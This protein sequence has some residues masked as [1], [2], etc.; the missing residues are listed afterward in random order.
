MSRFGALPAEL[1]FALD[2]VCDAFEAAWRSGA[3]AAIEDHLGAV[4]DSARPALLLALLASELEIRREL[5]ETP[6]PREYYGKFPGLAHLVDEAF[7]GGVLTKRSTRD[8]AEPVGNRG[9]SSAGTQDGPPASLGDFDIVG[10]LGRGGMGTVYR[11]RD[12][13]RSV[14]VA[15]KVVRRTDS[16]AL[17]RFKQ[18]FRAL[19]GIFHPNLA[20][21]HQLVFDGS[22][23]FFT[24]ELVDGVDFLNHVRSPVDRTEADTEWPVPSGDQGSAD[25]PTEPTPGAPPDP[26]Q[27]SGLF[28]S[29]LTPFQ[30]GRLRGAL[31]QLANGLVALHEA[32]W[33]HRDL[34]PANVM[35]SRR[36]RVVILDLGLSAEMD[37]TGLHASTDTHIL[38]TVTYMA[39]EQAAGLAVSPASDWYS[40]GVMLYEAL[41]GRPPFRGRPL[42]VLVE[43]QRYEPPAPR[44]LVPDVPE[45]LDALCVD[46]LRRLPE[47]RPAGREVIRRVGSGPVAMEQSSVPT[48]TPRPVTSWVGRDASLATLAAALATARRGTATAV[49]LAGPSGAGKS[50]LLRRFLDPLSKTDDTLVLSGQCY[51]RELVPYKAFDSLV[52]KLGRYLG[53]LPNAELQAVLPRDV[54]A[55]TRVFPVLGSVESVIPAPRGAADLSDPRDLRRRA[56]AALRELLSR[57]A[58]RRAL[59]LAVDDLQWGDPDSA[60]LLAELL[61]PPDAPSLLFLGSFRSEDRERS[62]FLR[63]FFA[64]RPSGTS[65]TYHELTVGPLMP[66]EAE[67]LAL[68]LLGRDDSAAIN[69]AKA[70][71][72]ESAGSPLFVQALVQHAQSR[73][74]DEGSPETPEV[75]LDDVLWS[76]VM[77]LPDDAR[78]LLETLSVAGRPLRVLEACRAS[79]VGDG[80]QASLPLLRT[81]RMIR[82]TGAP[83]EEEIE[84][85]HDRVR[86]TITSRLALE[87]RVGHHRRLAETFEASGTR[88]AEVLATHFREAG[89]PAA[90][91]RYF[92][93]AADRA[94]ASLAFH[95]A[96][97]LYREAL[98]LNPAEGQGSRE[99]RRRF[100]DSLAKAGRGAESAREYLKLIG[101]ADVTEALGLRQRAALLLLLSGRYDEGTSVLRE[102]LNASGMALPVGRFRGLLDLLIWRMLLR[103]RG[104]S[105]RERDAA[106]LSAHD[107][108]NVDI[109][110]SVVAGISAIDPVVGSVYQARGLLLAL[111]AGEPYRVA[112]ALAFEATHRALPGRDRTESIRRLLEASEGLAARLKNPH[113]SGLISLSKGMIEVLRGNWAAG[114]RLCREAEEVFTHECSAVQWVAHENTWAE[115][116]HAQLFLGAALINMGRIN[117]LASHFSPLMREAL[118]RDDMAKV[119]NLMHPILTFLRLA[120]D[121]PE[122]ATFESDRAIRGWPRGEMLVQHHNAMRSR[123]FI[124]LY[125]GDGTAAWLRFVESRRAYARSLLPQVQYLRI[126]LC[127]IRARSALAAA[128]EADDPRRLLFA[129][130][131]DARRLEREH[132]PWAEALATTV[133]AGVAAR[134]GQSAR[135]IA[136]LLRASA[137]IR[138]PGHGTLSRSVAAP[139]RRALP[140]GGRARHGR[141]RDALD[142]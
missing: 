97:G 33:I 128:M 125:C 30:L 142:G 87:D 102:V 38:G 109:C 90:A 19:A 25:E 32:G 44:Q 15:L 100:A 88:D 85:Y 72:R 86:E 63:S 89:D 108:I 24:M 137:T 98:D 115:T 136:L 26:R 40:V 67:A 122:T 4:P 113:V 138:R 91:S 79:G 17:S 62:P 139:A 92:A 68:E 103:L 82:S 47:G 81:S 46:L 93:A 56:F 130:E 52:D 18:E 49:F 36:G 75:G 59:V 23:W 10:E 74:D 9:G 135:A 12:R 129:A 65:A 124:D 5:G 112:R 16:S 123:A 121:E 120:A 78:R 119:A 131:S 99:L 73:L 83:A 132:L 101:D 28:P 71:A 61:S 42:E 80:A 117:E 106:K 104:L 1:L 34:K 60:A 134:R 110:W 54:R 140:G 39:P 2:G 70:I 43:K 29:P 48:P 105:F 13:R 58:D 114:A 66:S 111:C 7:A 37:T 41:T 51:E 27:T 8:T 53:R 55:L 94:D 126:E 77:R 45:D 6:Q 118:E 116:D 64:A 22:D 133:R 127:E 11:A 107:I 14:D 95:Q 76:A 96:V 21:L 50:A 20:T 69:L 84:T 57:L 31:R 35:V 3:R 141:R